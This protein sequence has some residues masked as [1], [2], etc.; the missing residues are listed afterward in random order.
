MKALLYVVALVMIGACA[1][2]ATDAVTPTDSVVCITIGATV[3]PNSATLHPGDTLRVSASLPSCGLGAPTATFRWASS[4][5]SVAVVDSPSGLIR[6]RSLGTATI[7]AAVTA[8]R[9]VKGA[10][11]LVVAQ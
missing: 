4:D 5:S 11:L 7:I 2:T 9:S 3:R 8:D 1:A 6:A 10:M